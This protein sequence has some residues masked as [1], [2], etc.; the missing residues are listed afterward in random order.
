MA[1]RGVDKACRKAGEGGSASA[2]AVASAPIAGSSPTWRMQAR[3]R[4]ESEASLTA[5][6]LASSSAAALSASAASASAR[7]LASCLDR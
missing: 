1:G 6:I 4:A 3:V 5:P 2:R 7:A